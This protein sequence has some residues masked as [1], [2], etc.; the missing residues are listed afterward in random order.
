MAWT[1]SLPGVLTTVVGG[2]SA[3]TALAR[4]L[5]LSEPARL[6]RSLRSSAALVGTMPAGRARQA[7]ELSIERDSLRLAAMTLVQKDID[8]STRRNRLIFVGIIWAVLVAV[9]LF[10]LFTVGTLEDL[11]PRTLKAFRTTLPAAFGGAATMIAL[12]IAMRIFA[13]TLNTRA[14][15]ETLAAQLFA[16]GVIDEAYVRCEAVSAVARPD[17]GAPTVTPQTRRPRRA[18]ARWLRGRPRAT[19]GSSSLSD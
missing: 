9:L 12:P 11:N 19:N 18:L 8:Q 4:V 6:K 14:Q 15:R 1:D 17:A 2:A 16:D 3:V 10:I 13:S 5:Q 7:L